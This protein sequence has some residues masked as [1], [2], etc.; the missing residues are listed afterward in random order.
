MKTFNKTVA[1]IL[2]ICMVCSLLPTV[3]ASAAGEAV[4]TN[5][6]IG[7][8]YY[9]KVNAL[10]EEGEYILTV[11][12]EA[13]VHG[14]TLFTFTQNGSVE[15]TYSI[16][17]TG[18]YLYATGSTLYCTSATI[19][20]QASWTLTME[21]GAVTLRNNTSSKYY[22]LYNGKTFVVNKN[23][24]DPIALYDAEGNKLTALPEGAFQAYI[25]NPEGTKFLSEGI[26]ADDVEKLVIS[27]YVITDDLSL[28]PISLGNARRA[29]KIGDGALWQYRDGKLYA[30]ESALNEELKLAEAA[31]PAVYADEKLQIG[32]KYLDVVGSVL[33]TSDKADAVQLWKKTSAPA[34][35]G[36]Y[37]PITSDIHYKYRADFATNAETGEVIGTTESVERLS[38]W[39]DK[40]SNDFGGIYFDQFIS[41]GDQAD[42][43]T[44]IKG[45][46]YWERVG[47]A[48]D[49]V[50]NHEKVLGGGFFI[51]GNHEWANG[52]YNT[53]KSTNETAKRIHTAGYVEETAQYVIYSFSGAQTNNSFD[54]ADINALDA[55][56]AAAPADKPIFII[57]HY[58]LHNYNRTER[59]RD[60]VVNVLNK[61]ADTKQIIFLWG[62]NHTEEDPNYGTVF[63]K[64]SENIPDNLPIKFTYA[65]AGCM[66]D[67][68][69]DAHAV[70]T[71]AKGLLAYI[72]P[73]A[74]VSLSY[75]DVNFDL[76]STTTLAKPA[77][78]APVKVE[79]KAATCTE[80]GIAAE[81]WYCD[82]CGV[83]FADEACENALA[84]SDVV[85]PVVAHTLVATEAKEATC[86]EAGNTAYWTC[87]VCGKTFSNEA[88][89][90]EINIESVVVAA[91]G[92]DYV[93]GVCSLCG[94]KEIIDGFFA[95][96]L[97]GSYCFDA[98]RWALEKNITNGFE[99]GIFAPNLGVTRSN[100][101]TMLWRAAGC[102]EPETEASFSDLKAGAYYTKAVA[103]AVENGITNGMGKNKFEPETICT[104]AQIVTFLWRYMGM[105]KAEAPAAFDDLEPGEYYIDAVAWAVEAGITTGI[106]EDLF[107]PAND[108]TR[109][110]AVTFLQRTIA[111]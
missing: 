37:L 81:C 63:G 85:I 31:D 33:S 106:T 58:P 30:G 47:V 70:A 52:Q 92:H 91:L 32:E 62:H 87:S 82:G 98:V 94:D 4:E 9:E 2:V 107:K 27:N 75:Y 80:T 41:C 66:T 19:S 13:T 7:A 42:A 68:E 73:D 40:I 39:L 74:A 11:R 101:V 88:A 69:Y 48:M 17:G 46:D 71:T 60:T 38:A 6:V 10:E 99:E 79:P 86:T 49:T 45:N 1:M 109:A 78:H 105:P 54:N 53:Y 104:R 57:S 34:Q 18:A 108:C 65:S 20:S 8:D 84:T 36:I 44:K 35:D 111:E 95:D 15:G 29:R 50:A 24:G 21:D 90:K 22:L 16:K 77:G 83:Y 61:Y 12:D 100:F 59:N 43:N 103:W 102:P 25:C 89:T 55:Y 96:V 64:D 14:G 56:L 3:F 51:N 26:A 5:A 67:D 76:M 72:A 97:P 23:L 93:N 110:Q 28:N